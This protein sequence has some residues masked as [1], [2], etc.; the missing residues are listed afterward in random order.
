MVGL[1]SVE[2]GDFDAYVRMRADPLMM[3]ELGGPQ[4]VAKVPDKVARDVDAAA[5]DRQWILMIVPDNAAAGVVAGTVA[6]WTPEDADPPR[7]SEIGWMVLPEF[8]G[9]QIATAAVRAVLKRAV[10]DTRWG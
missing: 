3:A 7:S 8:Q 9:Q 2:L 5:V 6:L 4:D 1:R 10:E